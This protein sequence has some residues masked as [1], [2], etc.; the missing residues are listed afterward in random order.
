MTH[1]KQVESQLTQAPALF[2]TKPLLHPGAVQ[3]KSEYAVLIL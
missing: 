3:V 2:K 1:D